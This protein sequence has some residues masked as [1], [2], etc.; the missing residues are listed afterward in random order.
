[1]H[2]VLESA[3]GLGGEGVG[4]VEY[5]GTEAPAVA[6]AAHLVCGRAPHE[7]ELVDRVEDPRQ[8]LRSDTIR[9]VQHIRRRAERDSGVLGDV[10][11][12][13][14]TLAG[15]DWLAPESCQPG[16]LGRERAS[17]SRC[18]A[19]STFSYTGLA[20]LSWLIQLSLQLR[21]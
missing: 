21:A 16:P 6:A 4:G 9:P 3:D 8:G 15:R 12:G 14:A 18:G 10:L 17:T 11:D 2:C 1:M 19:G 5:D 7:T 13:D 20:C